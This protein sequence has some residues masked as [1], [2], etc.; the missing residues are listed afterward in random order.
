MKN[1]NEKHIRKAEIAQLILLYHVY[2][3]AGSH[4]L[5]FQGG[6]ALRWCYGGNRFSEDLDFVTTMSTTALDALF[7]KALKGAEREMVPHFG[8]GRLAVTDKTVREGSRKLLV[9]WQA[10]AVREKTTIKLEC[11]PLVSGTKLATEQLVMSALPSVSYLVMAGEFRIPRPNSVLVV[12]TPSEII[13]D[14]VRALLER[15]YLKGRDLYDIW[16]LSKNPAAQLKRELLEQKLRCYS[17][18]FKASRTLDYFLQTTSEADLRETLE[19]DL[20]RFLP[21]GVMEVHRGNG[22]QDLLE[23]VRG[24]CREVMESGADLA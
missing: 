11:E 12:E 23:A 1:Y 18:P 7:A 22:F 24:L 19:R 9:T 6:T 10:D 4:S 16:L 13:S 20:S 3:Q 14:K 17:W 5:V 15:E 8:P 2:A 21:P